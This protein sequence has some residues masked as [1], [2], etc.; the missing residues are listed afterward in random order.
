MYALSDLVRLTPPPALCHTPRPMTPLVQGVI[1][2]CAVV[3]TIVLAAALLALRK[4]A[5]RAESVLHIVEQEIRPLASRVETLTGELGL[6]TR[7]ANQELDRVSGLVRSLEDASV[8]VARVAGAIGGFTRVGQVAGA[9]A[10]VK[11]GLDVFIR[12]FRDRHP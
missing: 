12:R 2:V 5:L 6:L 3:L 10:G 1:A 11:R 4:T 9:A 7:H 8:K